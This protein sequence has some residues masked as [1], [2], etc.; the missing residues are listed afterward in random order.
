ML[1]VRLEAFIIVVVAVWVIIT[2]LLRSA[3]LMHLLRAGSE[4]VWGTIT[5]HWH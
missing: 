5:S 3:E 2:V 4:L 1:T